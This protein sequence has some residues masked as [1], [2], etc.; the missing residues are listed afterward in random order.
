MDRLFVRCKSCEKEFE[1][2][3][4]VPPEESL[5]EG[6]LRTFNSNEICPFCHKAIFYLKGHFS[7]KEDSASLGSKSHDNC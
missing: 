1:T 6:K 7:L 5:Q 4:Q 3:L 2:S